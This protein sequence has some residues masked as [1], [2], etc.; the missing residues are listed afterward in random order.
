MSL[1]SIIKKR[2]DEMFM[3]SVYKKKKKRSENSGVEN[4]KDWTLDHLVVK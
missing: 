3:I 4:I 2:K 1:F